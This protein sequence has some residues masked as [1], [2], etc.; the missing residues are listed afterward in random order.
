MVERR[1]EQHPY[2]LC[3]KKEAFQE[4]YKKTIEFREELLEKLSKK[5]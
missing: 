5:S 4:F 1:F 3:P 2:L